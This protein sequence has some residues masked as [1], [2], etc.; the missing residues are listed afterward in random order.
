MT[1]SAGI[2]S[3]QAPQA[4]VENLL[5]GGDPPQP[6]AHLGR[7]QG[8]A[9]PTFA[10]AQRIRG[11]LRFGVVAHDL[12]ASAGLPRLVPQERHDAA[13]PKQP[14]IFAQMPSIVVCAPVRDGFSYFGRWNAR[15][16]IFP[17]KED[18]G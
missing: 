2:Q 10:F 17:R 16:L 9:Q 12:G 11:Q 3:H 14:S 4:V 8:N 1:F 7:I 6:R 15:R 13:H 5:I 18:E